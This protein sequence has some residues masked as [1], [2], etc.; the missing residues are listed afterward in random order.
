FSDYK[1]CTCYRHKNSKDLRPCFEKIGFK[2]FF[3]R[4]VHLKAL[5]KSEKD[6]FIKT[7]L[8]IGKFSN[9]ND[10]DEFSDD[11]DNNNND[12]DDENNNSKKSRTNYRYNFNASSRICIN[13]FIKLCGV[14]KKVFDNIKKHY[15]KFGLDERIHKNTGRVPG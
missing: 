10:D 9:N 5:N 12:E 15:K 4:F 3:K 14:S 11:D 1:N 8:M 7:Q 6:L 13:V 2:P